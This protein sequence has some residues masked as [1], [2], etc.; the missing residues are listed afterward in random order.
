MKSV[1]YYNDS[2]AKGSETKE[3]DVN[4]YI[5]N[6]L[7]LIFNNDIKSLSQDE[8]NELNKNENEK[9]NYERGHNENANDISRIVVMNTINNT[10]KKSSISVIKRN[11]ANVEDINSANTV[12]LSN[13]NTTE[14]NSLNIVIGNNKTTIAEQNNLNV[15]D[16][17]CT[18][19][20]DKSST[21]AE[22]NKYK[23]DADRKCSNEADRKCS[24]DA[25]RKCSNDADKKCTN[26]TVKSMPNTPDRSYPD[27]SDKNHLNIVDI[28]D[29]SVAENND[30]TSS[31]EKD[32]NNSLAQLKRESAIEKTNSISINDLFKLNSDAYLNID[33]TLKKG[34]LSEIFMNENNLNIIINKK[35]EKW[36]RYIK[37]I[38]PFLDV[39][40]IINLSQT[41]KYF[42]KRKYRVW[43]N[44]LIFNSYLGYNPKIIYEYVFPRIYKHIHRSVRRR[45]C[46][47]FTLCTLIKDITVA[48][49]LNQIYNFD[50]LNTKHLFIYNLQ[51]I[52]FD[53]CHHLTD[54]TLEVLAQTRLPSLKTLSIKCVRNKY[55]TCAPLTVML[56]KSNW[57]VFTNFIC[58]FSNAWLEPIFIVSNF[59]INRANNQNHLIYHKLK[60]LRK[61]LEN[62]K[63]FDNSVI[64]S[65]ANDESNRK[66]INENNKYNMMSLQ[67][68]ID[69]T[70]IDRTNLIDY[71]AV[72][73]NKNNNGSGSNNN[74]SGMNNNVDGSN[75]NVGGSNINIGGSN[76]NSNRKKLKSV[77]NSETECSISQSETNNNFS[78]FNNF[79]YN[80]MK[81]FG[82][83]TKVQNNFN[84]KDYNNFSKNAFQNKK[85][86]THIAALSSSTPNNTNTKND[87]EKCLNKSAHLEA[88]YNLLHVHDN[89]H[90]KKD[91][92]DEFLLGEYASTY[93]NSNNNSNSKERNNNFLNNFENNY[94]TTKCDQNGV[95]GK[96]E[97]REKEDSNEEKKEIVYKV[98][99]RSNSTDNMNSSASF[100]RRQINEHSKRKSEDKGFHEYFDEEKKIR[101][102]RKNE[103]KTNDKRNDEDSFHVERSNDNNTANKL[104]ENNLLPNH[105]VEEKSKRKKKLEKQNIDDNGNDN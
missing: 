47:D 93:N 11:N 10:A 58:S 44:R 37:C 96:Y 61:T 81:H 85:S 102:I 9:E 59:I 15:S 83:S 63:T 2:T 55:L 75:I 39:H 62:M 70:H 42:Y 100:G 76:N 21:N 22:D 26:D 99:I 87:H 14:K 86:D 51:E 46:L 19:V 20:A 80:T 67:S 68:C 78:L 95:N 82:Y 50:S 66:V 98:S 28:N 30:L 38:E 103:E 90:E 35:N 92:F 69:G 29:T 43:N 36:K 18:N 105:E 16:K 49:V 79:F 33:G 57:P 52:Y 13:A 73:N 53:Y 17:N 6:K 56:K 24:N 94:F 54:K 84:Q 64:S 48:N 8:D 25:D 34:N 40:T 88:E 77:L 97:K 104:K 23:N 31:I 41:C 27:I 89:M 1:E 7:R 91:I 65:S 74:I 3:D 60:N 72:L 5:L 101:K 12:D 45:L 4:K 71:T 32:G